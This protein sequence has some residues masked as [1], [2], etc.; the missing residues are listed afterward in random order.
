METDIPFIAISV[1]MVYWFV[2]SILV[3]C[4]VCSESYGL[5]L[6]SFGLAIIGV[7]AIGFLAYL[8][9]SDPSGIVLVCAY[10]MLALSV[11]YTLVI[12][13]AA[14]EAKLDNIENNVAEF[15]AAISMQPMDQASTGSGTE[16]VAN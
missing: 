11:W 8:S 14:Q 5:L 1:T 16:L 13:G 6:T 4:G 10:I 12:F 7:V 3:K 9:Y 2:L 15:E